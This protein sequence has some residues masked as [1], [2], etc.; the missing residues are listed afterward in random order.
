MTLQRDFANFGAQLPLLR[1]RPGILASLRP[2]V[3]LR[4]AQLVGLCIPQRVQRLFH[5]AANP[6]CS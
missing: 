1:T 6:G 4:T 2:F 3:A 5:R